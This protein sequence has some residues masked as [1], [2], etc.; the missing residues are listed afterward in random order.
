MQT[1]RGYSLRR[2]ASGGGLPRRP[3]LDFVI[4]AYTLHLGAAFFT[5]DT[6]HYRLAFLT[7]RL[8]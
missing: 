4:G 8:V 1:L 2:L 3:L 6:Q 5:L 7:L